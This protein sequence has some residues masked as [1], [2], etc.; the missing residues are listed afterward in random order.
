VGESTHISL[1]GRESAELEAPLDRMEASMLEALEQLGV[2]L[3]CS[4]EA[5]E[6]QDATLAGMVIAAD[7]YTDARFVEVNSG[8]VAALGQGLLTPAEIRT[9]MALLRISRHVERIGDQ[10]VNLAKLVRGDGREF[11]S[12]DSVI[13]ARL[14]EMGRIAQELLWQARVAL[15]ER[16]VALAENLAERDRELNDLN[17]ACFRRAVEIGDDHARREWAMYMMLAGR[18]LERIGDNAVDIGETVPFIATGAVR[19]F[20]G[21]ARSAEANG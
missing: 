13:F 16:D 6:H 15:A 5:I 12:T 14:G 3:E 10:C 20:K 8:V 7:D 19:E 17:R 1:F 21:S 2:S 4:I 9:G 11:R 18:W